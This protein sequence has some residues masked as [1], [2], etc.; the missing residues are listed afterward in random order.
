MRQ[1]HTTNP[2]DGHPGLD[3]F[4]EMAVRDADADN[5]ADTEA[6]PGQTNDVGSFLAQLSFQEAPSE[7]A[8]FDHEGAGAAKDVQLVTRRTVRH[9]EDGEGD[10]L[11]SAFQADLCTC[12]VPNINLEHGTTSFRFDEQ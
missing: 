3:F 7:R 12:D 4:I 8:V 6:L 10:D 11:S 5:I 2:A 9:A 1:A